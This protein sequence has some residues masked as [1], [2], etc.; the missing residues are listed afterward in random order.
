MRGIRPRPLALTALAALAACSSTLVYDAVALAYGHQ[1]TG[2]IVWPTMQEALALAGLDGI[3][4]YPVHDNLASETGV[5]YTGVVVQ[6]E[7]D[8]LYDP[9]ALY[10][11]I[12]AVKHQYGCFWRSLRETGTA[13][14]YA[15]ADADAACE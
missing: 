14:V 7:G 13:T 5:P 12:P 15:P 1:E 3:R 4:P 2:S 9:H 11:Q 10:S 8:G 6:Y